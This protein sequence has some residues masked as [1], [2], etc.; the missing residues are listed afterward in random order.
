MLK[1]ILLIQIQ[2]QKPLFKDGDLACFKP[3]LTK[4][5]GISPFTHRF[6]DGRVTMIGGGNLQI[7]DVKHGGVDDTDSDYATYTCRAE[8][9]V[10]SV[11]A[12]ARLNVLGMVLDIQHNY[13]V[14]F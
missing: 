7:L 3:H 10:D 13:T 14:Y 12:E 6:K 9:D 11:D 4:Y 2:I 8:N 1:N 5:H